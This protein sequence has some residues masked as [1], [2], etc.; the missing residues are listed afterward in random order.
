MK[1]IVLGDIH[2][3]D[4]WKDI[5]KRHPDAD[6][7]V[8]LGDYVSTHEDISSEVQCINL[9]NILDFKTANPDKVVLLRG[10][11][12]MQHLKYSWAECSG[13]DIRVAA[14]MSDIKDEFL[15]KTQWVYVYD[16]FVF[17]HAG[18]SEAWLENIGLD[19]INKINELEPS[20]KFA[21]WP[22][23]MSDYTGDSCTQPVTWI[24]P[25]ALI[26]YAYKD[27]TYIIGHTSYGKI[28][29]VKEECIKNYQSSWLY[30]E[31]DEH[32]KKIIEQYTNANDIYCCDALPNEYL[33]I[34]DGIVSVGK[35]IS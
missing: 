31:N 5:V 9:R 12:D 27:Y 32:S 16:K 17:S 28:I 25:W 1:I 22:C 6:K 19:D 15:V 29:N 24:R 4:C 7:Y 2:G 8:F 33:I 30:N 23:K 35:L 14:Y 21:F 26:E 18:V 20:E 34:E 11:H 13:Y 3:R 10:N